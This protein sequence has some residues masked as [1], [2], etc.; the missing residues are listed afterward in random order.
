MGWCNDVDKN[1]YNKLI[2]I[3]KIIKYEVLFRK[4]YK[5]NFL[6]LLNVTLRINLTKVVQYLFI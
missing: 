4:D 1:N 5:Y 6:I 3:N 2:N